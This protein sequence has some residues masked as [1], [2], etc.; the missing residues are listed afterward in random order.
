LLLNNIV[1]K[2]DMHLSTISLGQLIKL[3]IV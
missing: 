3:W 1:L 2:N